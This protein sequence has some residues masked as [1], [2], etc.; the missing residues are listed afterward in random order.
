MAAE[1]AF[2]KNNLQ[3]TITLLDGTGTPVTLT[4]TT[5]RGD[6][7]VTNLSAKLNAPMPLTRRGRFGSLNRGERLFIGVSL[8]AWVGNLVGSSTSVP[9]TPFEFLTK[10]GAYSANVSTLGANR[11]Y[12]VDLRIT[13]EGTNFG[14]TADE[15]LTVEDMVAVCEWA[16]AIDGNVLTI[17]GQGLGAVVHVNSTNTVT[18]SQTS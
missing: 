4:M 18:L 1:S 17:S 16:E 14:D 15:T 6:L 12:C 9:G 7:K 10:S 13:N 3:G 5:D 2:W 11:E 8:T